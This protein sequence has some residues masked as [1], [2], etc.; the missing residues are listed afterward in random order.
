VPRRADELVVG[1][2]RLGPPARTACSSC[3][4]P[5]TTVR[6]TVSDSRSVKAVAIPAMT[7]M[8]RRFRTERE[9][10]P[11]VSTAPSLLMAGLLVLFAYA[12]TASR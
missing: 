11:Y 4:G 3:S 9:L 12:I 2:S 10:T 5:S 7:R 6:Y 8:D 1:Q